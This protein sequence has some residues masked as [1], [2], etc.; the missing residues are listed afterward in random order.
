[1]FCSWDAEEFALIGSVEFA[2]TNYRTLLAQAISYINLDIAVSGTDV[3]YASGA[4]SLSSLMQ[5]VTKM[6]TLPEDKKKTV[7]DMWYDHQLDPM[8]TGSDHTAFMMHCAISSLVMGMTSF[9]EAYEAVYHSNYDSFYWFSHWGDPTF[10]YHATMA[11]VFGSLAL[12]L[13]DDVVLPFDFRDYGTAMNGYLADLLNST[14]QVDFTPM[15]QAISNFNAAANTITAEISA[16]SNTTA[17]GLRRSLNDRLMLTER[18][19]LG[20]AVES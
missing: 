12:R 2:E 10:E 6:V 20:S 17:W 1:V 11:K 13:L 8:G 4:P 16:T 14:N 7:Y 15:K 19:F 18:A 9:D 5:N 3:F